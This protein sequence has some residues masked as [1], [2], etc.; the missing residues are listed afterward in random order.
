MGSGIHVEQFQRS[1][2][3]AGEVVKDVIRVCFVCKKMNKM[4]FTNPISSSV[5]LFYASRAGR[6]PCTAAQ[7]MVETVTQILAEG[8]GVE[9]WL[10]QPDHTPFTPVTVEQLRELCK[11]VRS[12]T[13]HSNVNEWGPELVS[14]EIRLAAHIGAKALVV[15]PTAFGDLQE[16]VSS[17]SFAAIHDLCSQARDCGMLL[18]LENIL[19]GM[20]PLQRALDRIGYEPAET[21]LAVCIDIGHANRSFAKDGVEPAIFFKTFRDVIVEV[22]IHDNNGEKDE[23]LVPGKGIVNWPQ[24]FSAVRSLPQTTLLCL[25][26]ISPENPIDALR[27]GRQFIYNG[28]SM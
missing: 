3:V 4:H 7:P 25:E 8:L 5:E 10:S 20:P 28:L 1:L 18:V 26:L 13:A 23:H 27:K 12:I 15:H 16:D 17:A 11:S 19:T 21:G 14:D 9:L 2:A 22:H 24:L 6:K